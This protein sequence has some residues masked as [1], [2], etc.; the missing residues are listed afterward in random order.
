MIIIIINI[1]FSVIFYSIYL[2]DNETFKHLNKK[3]NTNDGIEYF[4]FFYYTMTSFFRLG[5]DI[6][7]TS[8]LTKILVVIHI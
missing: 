1:I 2:N 5:Y 6:I 4:D 7:P 8:K 3:E